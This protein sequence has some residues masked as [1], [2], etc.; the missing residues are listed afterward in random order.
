MLHPRRML[1]FT[2][3]LVQARKKTGSDA[4]E[5]VYDGTVTGGASALYVV[6]DG[7]GTINVTSVAT[8]GTKVTLNLS[9]SISGSAFVSYGYSNAEGASWVKDTQPG[10][11]PVPCFQSVAVA[12]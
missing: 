9:R 11:V 6:T 5:L 7:S 1:I 4:I 12:P 2:S 10:P 3:P 8:S